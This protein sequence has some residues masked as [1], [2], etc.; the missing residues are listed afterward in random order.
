MIDEVYSLHDDPAFLNTGWTMQVVR[1]AFLGAVALALAVPA[2]QFYDQP[3][4]TQMLPVVALNAFI[5]GFISTKMATANRHLVMGRL[6]VVELG[7]QFISIVTM[8]V[9][10]MLY[11]SVWA[12]IVGIVVGTLVKV[13]LS[14]LYLPG[15]R[16]RMQFEKPAFLELFHFGKYL[17]FSSIATF[18]I[19]H[20]DRAILGKFVSLADLAFYNIAFFFATVPLVLTQQFVRKIML[21]LYSE[22]PPG[23]SV[24]NRRKINRARIL[25]TAA[26]VA[27]AL[28]LSAIGDWLVPFLYTP[29]YHI[30]GPL[31]VVLAL[32]SL[33]VLI[34]SSYAYLL[35]SQGNSRGYSIILLATAIL[36][37]AIL[38]YGAQ[39]F[40][41]LGAVFAPGAAAI[42]IYPLLVWLLRPYRGW[43][44][45]HD[46]GF[47]LL[48]LGLGA[49][50]LYFK[51]EIYTQLLVFLP[52]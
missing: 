39:R 41:V 21:P 33:P 40:G 8:I 36:Q 3:L 23:A 13:A 37:T 10:A 27:G 26:M 50:I 14:H 18:F 29:E 34:T 2:A 11:E 47:A 45:R 20:A 6:T 1:G 42:L 46:I 28:I 31:L 25:L 9:L 24:E 22:K 32:G 30:A 52:G 17:F 15:V 49:A 19:H 5:Y 44:P 43:D 48:S 12:L 4:M 51:P 38:I 16:N 7:S 35:V